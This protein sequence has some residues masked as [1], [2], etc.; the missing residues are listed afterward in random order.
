M[1]KPHLQALEAALAR[2]GWQVLTVHDGD[3]YAIAAT[4]EIQR[5]TR[6]PSLFI[7]FSGMSLDGDTCLPLTQSYGCTL[8]GHP[9][10][11]LYFRRVNKSQE[12]WE[13][14][15]AEFVRALDNAETANR[16]VE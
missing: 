16:L 8:R 5:S 7:D 14:D 12:R 4:W 1:S 15:L 2:R 9:S 13:K 3:E 6:E 10:V 11:G